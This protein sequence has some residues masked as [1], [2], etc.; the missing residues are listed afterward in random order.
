M[1]FSTIQ[2]ENKNL[3]KTIKQEH[4]KLFVKTATSFE[5]SAF[6]ASGPTR[7][8]GS[9]SFRPEKMPV[10]YLSA[11]KSDLIESGKFSL[12]FH[13]M[14]AYMLRPYSYN[15]EISYKTTTN[16]GL[17]DKIKRH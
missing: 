11:R 14:C 6:I 5:T 16:R 15:I 1:A 10:H 3:K 8:S 4:D 9:N 17:I 2:N 12:F 7:D 13:A